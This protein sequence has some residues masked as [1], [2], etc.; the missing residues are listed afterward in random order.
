MFAVSGVIDLLQKNKPTEKSKQEIKKS[1]EERIKEIYEQ[2][3]K[4]GHDEKWIK[5]KV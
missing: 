2:A 5:K 3:K 1:V 4:E